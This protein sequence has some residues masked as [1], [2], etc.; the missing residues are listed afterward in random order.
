M[1]IGL[2]ANSKLSQTQR[3]NPG[4]SAPGVPNLMRAVTSPDWEPCDPRSL[5]RAYAL[6]GWWGSCMI[7]RGRVRFHLQTLEPH[8]GTTL[9]CHTMQGLVCWLLALLSGRANQGTQVI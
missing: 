7:P 3:S 2:S 5:A 9:S 8:P 6:Q 4:S 1:A